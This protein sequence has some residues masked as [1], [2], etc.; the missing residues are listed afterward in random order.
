MV[1]LGQAQ[2]SKCITCVVGV[3]RPWLMSDIVAF[4]LTLLTFWVYHADR[5]PQPDSTA[6]CIDQVPPD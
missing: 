2:P 1:V 6:R 4:Q 5:P 3:R